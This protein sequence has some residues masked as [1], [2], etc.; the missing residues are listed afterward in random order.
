MDKSK[1]KQ[2]PVIQHHY[3]EHLGMNEKKSSHFTKPEDPLPSSQEPATGSYREPL[4]TSPHI[5][6][7]LLDLL[8][9]H[10]ELRLRLR[11]GLFSSSFSTNILFAS[12]ISL[13]RATCPAYSLFLGLIT[14]VIC[15]EEH[16]L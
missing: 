15:D 8:S 10:T 11:S 2:I 6:F 13:I 4:E 5:Q 1:K 3:Q 9:F 14:L 7:Q 12:F 16:S